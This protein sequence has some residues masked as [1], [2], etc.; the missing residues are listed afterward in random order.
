M[1]EETGERGIKRKYEG[2][3]LGHRKISHPLKPKES[4]DI[5]V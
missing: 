3:D 4:N 1:L 2:F 5:E